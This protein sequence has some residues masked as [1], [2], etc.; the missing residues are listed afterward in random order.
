MVKLEKT[1]REQEMTGWIL[2]ALFA[3]LFL[4]TIIGWA[5]AIVILAKLVAKLIDDG[6]LP[7]PKEF[8]K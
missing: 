2:F 5:L 1:E 8:E 6:I 4:G 7:M 3:G